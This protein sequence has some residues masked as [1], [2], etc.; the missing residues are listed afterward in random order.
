MH[1]LGA[2]KQTIHLDHITACMT[3]MFRLDFRVQC[4]RLNPELFTM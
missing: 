3:W 2:S 4:L 1:M